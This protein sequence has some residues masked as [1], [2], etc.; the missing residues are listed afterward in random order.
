MVSVTRALTPTVSTFAEM[1]GVL[2]RERPDAWTMDA[3]VAWVAGPDLQV[4][5]SAGH[6]FLHRGDAWFVSA[7]L[8]LRRRP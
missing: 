4:D 2:L 6:T 1:S 5:V 8:T 3:G 7:G